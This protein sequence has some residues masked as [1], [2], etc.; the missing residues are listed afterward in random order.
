[1]NGRVAALLAVSLGAGACRKGEPA[2]AADAAVEASTPTASLAAEPVPRC[3]PDPGG[4]ALPP[5]ALVGDAVVARD[6]LLV[7]IVHEDKGRRVGA[8]VRAPLDLANMAVLEV[9][10]AVGD[11]PPPS[12]RWDGDAAHVAYLVRHAGAP[13]LVNASRELRVARLEPAAIG[14]LEGSASQQA[15]ESTSFD[16]AWPDRAATD[17][18][19]PAAIAAWDE[20]ARIAPGRFLPDRGV[21]KVQLLAKGEKARVVS[22]DA[23]DAESPRLLARPGGFW[24]AWLARHVEEQDAGYAVE[25]PAERSGFRFV[26]LV[27]L[28]ARGELASAVRRITPEKGSATAFELARGEGGELVVLVQ[29]ETASR[30]GAGA[31]VVRHAVLDGGVESAD[32]VDGGV[33]QMVVDLVGSSGGASGRWLSWTD[34]GE[35]AFVLPLTPALSAEARASLEPSLDGA[36][37]LAATPGAVYAV[38]GG[39]ADGASGRLE[40]RRFACR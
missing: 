17:G 30:E 29:D 3:R 7:G 23:S 15:D 31:R 37:L 20:D 36:R 14:A 6:A 32:M 35:R 28:D 4:L 26:E 12:P 13:G 40:L 1:M 9:G 22:P 33:G 18:G 10:P 34:L 5:D 27:A 8:I 11:D 16:V 2:A 24:L 19:A 38:L 39:A 25:S 21:V